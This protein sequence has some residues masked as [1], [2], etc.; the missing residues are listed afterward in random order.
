[1][2]VGRILPWAVDGVLEDAS[3][4]A[5]ATV[6]PLA[7]LACLERRIRLESVTELK[8][9]RLALEHAVAKI[10]RSGTSRTR[11]RVTKSKG[12]CFREA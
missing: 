12:T 7:R 6:P 9:G 2:V 1:M 4:V 8:A 10:E 11:A 5:T 3:D